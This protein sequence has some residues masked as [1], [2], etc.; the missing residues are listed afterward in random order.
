MLAHLVM[1]SRYPLAPPVQ[2]GWAGLIEYSDKVNER[3]NRTWNRRLFSDSCRLIESIR[4]HVQRIDGDETNP[5]SFRTCPLAPDGYITLRYGGNLAPRV[6]Y[7]DESN[8][9]RPRTLDEIH[10]L[11]LSLGWIEVVHYWP[12]F[13]IVLDG[14]KH[15]KV[16]HTAS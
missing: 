10:D 1:D 3:T 7:R 2:T 5:A 11:A 16:L 12:M 4:E 9:P 13:S 6:T 15:T 8:R 14:K